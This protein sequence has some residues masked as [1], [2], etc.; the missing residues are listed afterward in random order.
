MRCVRCEFENIPGQTRCIRCGSI[1]EMGRGAVAIYPPRMPAWRKP[2]RH[3]MRRLR[4]LHLAPQKSVLARI[5]PRLEPVISD[6]L[7]G[8]VLN[9]IPGFAHLLN[10]RLREVRLLLPLWLVLLGAGLFLY[11]S[12]MGFLLIGL[13]IGTHAWIAISYGLFREVG[14]FFARLGAALV[15]VVL[16]AVLYWA[17]PRLVVPS[18]TPAYTAL[19]IPA[20]HVHAGDTFLVWRRDGAEET[21]LRGALVLIRPPNLVVG[22][23]YRAGESTR[24]MIGQV[25]GL[26]HEVV[27]IWGD[28]FV[29]GRKPLDPNSFPVPQWL[30]RRGDRARVPV[31]AD[32]YFVSS[33]YTLGGRT[34]VAVTDQMIAN[35]CLVKASDIRGRPFLHWWPLRERKF[36]NDPHQD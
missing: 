26:P 27:Q 23:E 17:T 24:P 19:T 5:S 7:V 33:E 29:I 10:G 20:L 22:R 8:L 15:V 2:F 12:P 32:S 16:L 6:S 31:P 30:R 13:A 18:L 25:V 21:L 34:N 1:L 4:G 28:T 14:D 11:G 35:A 36:V 3:A 9:A